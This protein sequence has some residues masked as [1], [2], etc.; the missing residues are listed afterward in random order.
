MAQQLNNEGFDTG[1]NY[2]FGD[3]LISPSF[4]RSRFDLSHTVYRDVIGEGLVFPISVVEALPNSDYEI[5]CQHLIRVLPQVVPL[6]TRQRLYLYA[7]YSR[8]SDLWSGFQTFVRK[9]NSG[10]VVKQV[11]TINAFNYRGS[12]LVYSHN[13]S[14]VLSEGSL[15]DYFG[16]LPVGYSG[17]VSLLGVQCLPWMMYA[18]IWRDYFLN[19]NFFWCDDPNDDS[20][21]V[22][23]LAVL[24]E[25]DSRFRLNDNGQIES[26]LDNGIDTYFDVVGN[27]SYFVSGSGTSADP[28]VLNKSFGMTFRTRSTVPSGFNETVFVVSPFYHDYP[29]DY[30][31]SALPWAQRG[32]TP[33]LSVNVPD[34]VFKPLFSDSA[35]LGT[36]DSADLGL[37][38]GFRSANTIDGASAVSLYGGTWRAFYG[39]NTPAS[40]QNLTDGA[41]YSNAV[42][43]DWLLS[44][45][46]SQSITVEQLRELSISQTIL[47]KMARTDGSY[48]EFGLTFFG[49]VS[50]AATDYRPTFVGGSYSPIIYSEVI[51]QSES[52]STSPLGAYAGH[53]FSSSA[54]SASNGYLGRFHSDDYGF[55]MVLG[56]IMPDVEY[57]QGL[58]KMWTRVNQEEYFLPE[59]AMLGMQPILNQELYVQPSTVVDTDS[60]PVNKGLWAWQDIFDEYRYRENRIAGKLSDK[61]NK[62]FYPWTQS[63]YFSSL[64]NWGPDFARASDVRRTQL[65][66]YNESEFVCTFDIGIRAVQPLPYQAR[67]ASLINGQVG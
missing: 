13:V 48:R 50:K 20:Y 56:C 55:I 16:C 33:T 19:R 3:K 62:T 30:F 51:Q 66:A 61:D 65:A 37:R 25:D 41:T 11:P 6:L 46:D 18:R 31:T 53:G 14:G 60:Q 9:G 5:S 54:Q 39:A 64:P 36:F 7:F 57:S 24:P 49:E 17:D 32:N 35:D 40:V 52:T 23:N 43:K 29:A 1:S 34:D 28:Y 4:P 2:A 12:G 15:G 44:N 59:R 27:F 38:F 45:L 67:P 10:N 58:S 22:R 21:S 8:S 63:R 26:M 42:F 47:E